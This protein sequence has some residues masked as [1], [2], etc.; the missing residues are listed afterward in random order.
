MK[1]SRP[2]RR[3]GIVGYT[4]HMPNGMMPSFPTKNNP[5]ESIRSEKECVYLHRQ[6]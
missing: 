1:F 6:H 4:C 5:F 3:G 2:L